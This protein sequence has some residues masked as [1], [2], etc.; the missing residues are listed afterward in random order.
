MIVCI[1]SYLRFHHQS[2]ELGI[3]VKSPHTQQINWRYPGGP[4]AMQYALLSHQFNTT[5]IPSIASSRTSYQNAIG[6]FYGAFDTK[7]TVKNFVWKPDING[8]YS[9][10]KLTNY[11]I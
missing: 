5:L 1:N 4:M 2:L 10:L 11:R 9:L 3:L 6:L 8:V 7:A